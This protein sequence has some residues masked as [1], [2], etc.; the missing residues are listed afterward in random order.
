MVDELNEKFTFPFLK[1]V[2]EI[3]DFGHPSPS[4]L[5]AYLFHMPIYKIK[6]VN[7]KASL[8][9]RANQKKISSAESESEKR[10][11]GP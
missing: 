7:F 10:Y 5:S 11:F 9:T 1:I 8:K 2:I 3:V 4:T 6:I